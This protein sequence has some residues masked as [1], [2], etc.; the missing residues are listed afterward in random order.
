MSG[1]LIEIDKQTGICLVG[2]GETWRHLFAQCVLKITG[3]KATN[4]Y[5]YNQICANLEAGIDG[6]IHDVQA[7]WGAKSSTEDWG[8]LLVDAKTRLTISTILQFCGQFLIYGRPELVFL[9]LFR[10]WLLLILQ[11]GNGA[12]SLLHSTEGVM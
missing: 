9:N 11:N 6:D 5:Q 7:I 12:A 4:A 10:Q 8:F 3:T 2:V 1:R